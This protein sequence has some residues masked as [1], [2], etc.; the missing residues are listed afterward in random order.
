MPSHKVE[1]LQV[2]LATQGR[3][4]DATVELWQGPENIP[5]KMRVYSENGKQCPF[6]TL[7]ET[8]VGYNTLAVKNTANLEFPLGA[9]V[10]DADSIRPN[11]SN[12]LHSSRVTRG[13]PSKRIQGNALHT[14]KYGQEVVSL[15]IV[16]QTDGLPM[17]ARVE[18]SQ[19]P[20]NNKQIIDVYSQDGMAYP[21]SLVVETP[22]NGK[23]VRIM[24]TAS[25]EYPLKA[26]IEPCTNAKNEEIEVLRKEDEMKRIGPSD[27]GRDRNGKNE[28][29]S[30]DSDFQRSNFFA[31]RQQKMGTAE[32]AKANAQSG[33]HAAMPYFWA[34]SENTR[35]DKSAD[36]LS[37][38]LRP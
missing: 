33:A 30:V 18:L 20:N 17:S 11:Y 9:T 29:D 10:V 35:P 21:V 2:D 36:P 6:S 4:L 38:R 37:P 5:Q 1:R 14:Y 25:V 12:P 31:K 28:K 26:W 7:I 22:G 13:R 16:L 34:Q 15:Q 19:G 27:Y 3:P 32:Q 23:V 8:P 24:N